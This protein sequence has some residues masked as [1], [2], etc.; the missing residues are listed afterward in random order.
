MLSICLKNDYTSCND[1]KDRDQNIDPPCG[2]L[3]DN[4][5]TDVERNG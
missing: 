1:N 5:N 2:R 4:V 3:D